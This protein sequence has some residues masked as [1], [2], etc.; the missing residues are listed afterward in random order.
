MPHRADMADT[1][2]RA[3]QGLQALSLL[4][5]KQGVSLGG[6]SLSERSLVFTL[7][8]TGLPDGALSEREVNALLKAQ[9]AAALSFLE[10]DHV[11]LRRWLVD[12]GWMRRDGYGREYQRTNVAQLAAADQ[13]LAAHLAALDLQAWAT[14]QRAAHEARRA[15][16]RLSWQHQQGRAA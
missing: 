10:T 15:A 11:E 1:A 16:R 14:G 13:A 9:L 3:T 2:D 5:V 12:G 6:L 8:W 7:A 4:V